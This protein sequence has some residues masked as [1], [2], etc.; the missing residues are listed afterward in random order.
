MRALRRDRDFAS[1][2]AAAFV[3]NFGTMLRHLA[4]PLVA[5]LV[6][7]AGPRHI[8]LLTAAS[9]LPGLLFGLHA[10]MCVDRRRRR[11]ILVAS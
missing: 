6:L 7:D 1:F 8:A 9:L 5:I 2:W 10:G 11:P 3:S 4:L